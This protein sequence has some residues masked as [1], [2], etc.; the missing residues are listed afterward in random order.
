VRVVALAPSRLAAGR[1]SRWS[2]EGADAPGAA[3]DP[4]GHAAAVAAAAAAHPRAVVYPATEWS[5]SACL[6]AEGGRL[7]GRLPYPETAALDVLRQKARMGEAARAAGLGTPE[8]LFEGRA[9]D[10]DA[11][12]LTTPCVVKPSGPGW[13]FAA[14]AAR[15]QAE[16]AHAL[17]AAPPGA[18]LLVQEFVEGPLMAVSLVVDSDGAVRA[19]F[20]QRT[21]RVW[22]AGA[23][24]SA[25]A[26]G[27][28]P[29]PDL[30]QRVA[31]LLSAAGYAGLAQV[32]YVRADRGP[33]V[34]DVN[35]RFYGSMPLALASGV[36]LPAV[37]HAAVCGAPRQPPPAHRAGVSYR[38][39]E[40]DLVDALHGDLRWLRGPGRPR[41]GAWWNGQDPLPGLVLTGE[42]LQERVLSRLRR[43]G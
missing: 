13:P 31:G 20:H 34:L 39:M 26:V 12:A 1:V 36:N 6:E 14:R 4:S 2:A 9:A 24:V 40:P 30:T 32:Q 27:V 21:L 33:V 7:R 29:E 41:V 28:E 5:L 38:W 18:G 17:A 3:A 42:A 25:R 23:G 10:A 8:V 22:P 19:H 15:N 11:G 16:V 37:W 35:P 43:D